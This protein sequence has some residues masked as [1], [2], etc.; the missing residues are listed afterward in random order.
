[1]PTFRVYIDQQFL[2]MQLLAIP[3]A[4]YEQEY[5]CLQPTGVPDDADLGAGR[6]VL[7]VNVLRMKC[8]IHQLGDFGWTKDEQPVFT[9]C[10]EKEA[11]NLRSVVG[12]GYSY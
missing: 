10:L 9:V 5:Y 7:W 8:P 2:K 11:P 12:L 1:M 4:S 3:K 6:R